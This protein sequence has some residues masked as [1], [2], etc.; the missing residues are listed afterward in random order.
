MPLIAQG[1][2]DR[3]Y[4]TPDIGKI[5]GGNMLRVMERVLDRK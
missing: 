2:L 3:G 1:L 5:L 4:S